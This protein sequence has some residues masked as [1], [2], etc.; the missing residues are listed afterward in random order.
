HRGAGQWGAAGVPARPVAGR[1]PPGRP[2]RLAGGH[3][4]GVRRASGH[5]ARRCPAAGTDVGRRDRACPCLLRRRLVRTLRARGLPA[6]TTAP[7]AVDH[8]PRGGGRMIT[9][10]AERPRLPAFPNPSGAVTSASARPLGRVVS[11]TPAAAAAPAAPERT[12]VA[13]QRD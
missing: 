3:G 11:E 13:A 4:R 6:V 8:R 5:G 1:G 2:H 12:A 7:L 9:V 10:T